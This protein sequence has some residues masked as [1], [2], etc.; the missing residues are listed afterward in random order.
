MAD[1]YEFP[2]RP[3]VARLSCAEVED[4][5]AA[6]VWGGLER[7]ERERVDRHRRECPACDQRLLAAERVVSDLDRAGPKNPPPP[8]LRG[9]VLEAI[10]R[11][12][13]SPGGA[14]PRALVSTPSGSR[15][16]SSNVARDLPTIRARAQRPGPFFTG[17]ATGLFGAAA[18]A[19][20]VGVLLIRP[21]ALGL[22]G[23]PQSQF[24]SSDQAP[25]VPSITLPWQA[26]ASSSRLI[27]LRS[28]SMPG[29]AL[30]AFDAETR[31]GVL[32]LEAVS[33][34][35]SAEYGV[36]LVQ[37][38]QRIQLGSVSVDAQGVGTFVLPEPLPLDRP[39]RIEVA[40]ITEASGAADGVLSAAF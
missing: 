30:L 37:G 38:T 16:V 15:E 17:L 25:R 27:E 35:T 5:Q 3:E 31:R 20:L 6:Y 23:A 9:R 29:R 22:V 32:L 12:E 1:V 33:A 26:P 2:A 14:S 11:L 13:R 8:E 21:E 28:G 7:A 34:S 24:G 4:D 19:A 40:R 39:E 36:W 10:A 18:A